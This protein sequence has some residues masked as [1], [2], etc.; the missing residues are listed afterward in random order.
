MPLKTSPIPPTAK[1]RLVQGSW[2][3]IGTSKAEGSEGNDDEA[4]EAIHGG[5]VISSRGFPPA[6]FW[7]LLNEQ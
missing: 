7:S 4:C 5:T 2:Q 3:L 6:Q 1:I